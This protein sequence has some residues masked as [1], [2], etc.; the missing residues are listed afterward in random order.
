M[1]CEREIL[2]AAGF[3][4]T[5]LKALPIVQISVDQQSCIAIVDSGC[6]QTIVNA[7]LISNVRKCIGNVTTVD[8]A[9]VTING[10]K[11]VRV[12]VNENEMKLDCLVMEK[13][14]IGADV[15]LG[16]DAIRCLGGVFIGDDERVIFGNNFDKIEQ[17]GTVSSYEGSKDAAGEEYY[18]SDCPA[19]KKGKKETLCLHMPEH[20]KKI[21]LLMM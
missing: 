2:C 6:S 14:I 19:I 9:T 18:K 16:M 17:I 8:G 10:I 4:K 12:V 13:M 5:G 20:N 1:F 11:T 15:I 7:S 21:W 3:P